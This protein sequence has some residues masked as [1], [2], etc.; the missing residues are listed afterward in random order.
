LNNSG[1][2]YTYDMDRKNLRPIRHYFYVDKKWPIENKQM[3]LSLAVGFVWESADKYTGAL[4]AGRG[5]NFQFIIR[6]NIEF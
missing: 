1:F 4:A 3:A 6:P 5:N 2:E